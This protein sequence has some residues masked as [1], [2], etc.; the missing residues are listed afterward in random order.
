MNIY[1]YVFKYFIYLKIFYLIY[2]FYFDKNLYG[3]KS[4]LEDGEHTAQYTDAVL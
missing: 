3:F 2:I 4:N 1:F